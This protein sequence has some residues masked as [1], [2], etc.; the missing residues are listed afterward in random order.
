MFSLGV[1]TTDK[2]NTAKSGFFFKRGPRNP[3]YHRYWFV[4][5][6]N[7]LSYYKS[8]SSLYF[9]QGNVDLRNAVSAQLEEA[10]DDSNGKGFSV[11]TSQQTYRFKAESIASAQEWVK[12]IQ[13]AIFHSHTA[14][15]TVKICLPIQNML[16]VEENPMFENWN[17]LKIKV[18]DND[19]T[20]AIDEV[21]EILHRDVNR[22]L[23]EAVFFLP[24][25]L[26]KQCVTAIKVRNSRKYFVS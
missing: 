26:R 14:G 21:C 17:T 6:G 19:E 11:T 25:E 9:P 15:N 12:K 22:V 20:F 5:K 3:R 18:V 1:L 8:S 2:G 7:V 4:L 13:R 23:T 10:T 16:E 24:D